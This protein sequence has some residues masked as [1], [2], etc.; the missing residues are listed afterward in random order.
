MSLALN[1]EANVVINDRAFNQHLA[2]RLDALMCSACSEVT[3][4]AI[5]EE[6]RG[7]GVVRSFLAYHFT[8]Y[9]P[10]WAS[11]LPTHAPRLFPAGKPAP[12]LGTAS[13]K[14]AK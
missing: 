13:L 4:A 12:A 9:Y 10:D 6:N 1:L 8:R 2:E 7:W 11:S 3:E 14:E 5:E